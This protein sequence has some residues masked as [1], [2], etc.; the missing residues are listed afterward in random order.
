MDWHHDLLV[1]IHT[2]DVLREFYT[3]MYEAMICSQARLGGG[4]DWYNTILHIIH[5]LLADNSLN[6]SSKNSHML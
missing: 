4:G 6:E 5:A 3:Q 2:Q 1:L